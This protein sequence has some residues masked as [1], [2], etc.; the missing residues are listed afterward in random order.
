MRNV[1]YGIKN[2]KSEINKIK[3]G[4]G[5]FLRMIF[6]LPDLVIMVKN[7]IVYKTPFRM[8]SELLNNVSVSLPTGR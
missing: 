5:S 1:E 3:R 8:G 2:L 4:N 6:G 7:Q